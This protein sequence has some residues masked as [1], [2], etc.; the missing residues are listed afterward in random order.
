MFIDNNFKDIKQSYQ[1]KLNHPFNSCET[2]IDEVLKR[3]KKLYQSASADNS[4]IR[5]KVIKYC[6]HSLAPMLTKLLN[7]CI[8]HA[9]VTN[10]CKFAIITPLFKGKGARDELDNYHGKSILQVIAKLFERV[11]CS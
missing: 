8:K 6:A 2:S 7:L 5:T 4:S 1:L 10:D 3:L 9:A 11:L